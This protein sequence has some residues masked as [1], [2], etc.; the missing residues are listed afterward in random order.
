MRP[1]VSEASAKRRRAVVRRG[2]EHV[3]SDFVPRY[4]QV[5]TV[6]SQRVRDGEWTPD[7]P[8]PTEQEFAASFGVSRVTI[9][10]ALNMLQEERL[11]LRQQGRGTF[12]LPPPRRQSR[13]NFSG[14]LENVADF[15]L[16]TKVR[17]LSFGKVALPDETAR[18]LECDPGTQALR[19]VRV[20][21]DSQ[22]PFSFTTTHVPEPEAD[23]LDEASLGNQTVSSALAKAGVVTVSAEQRLSATVAG[24]EV[25]KHLRI[26]VGAPLI[27]MTRVMRNE[28]GR[29]VEVIHA[30]YRPDKYEYRVN[31]SRDNGDA[32]RWTVKI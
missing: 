5:Y 17:V 15:E 31:L 27:S 22:S 4:Y 1:R 19:I 20:R 18:L 6:L 30:L 14:L 7:V 26:D 9:R 21:S 11:V 13:A 29:P 16:H 24:V 8:M 3:V 28:D 32:P 2:A 25:A 12:A 10:K 23:L